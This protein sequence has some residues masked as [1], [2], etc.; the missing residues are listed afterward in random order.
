MKQP[1]IIVI[2]HGT[3]GAGPGRQTAFWGDS[4]GRFGGGYT[5]AYA[6][7]DEDSAVAFATREMLRY[8]VHRP[9]GALLVAPLAIEQRVN[10]ALAEKAWRG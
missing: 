2:S 6:G 8:G 3:R 1:S 5:G 10:A 7:K 4:S 9:G